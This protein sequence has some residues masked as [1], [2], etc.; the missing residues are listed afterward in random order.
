MYRK[1]LTWLALPATPP[2]H[3][4]TSSSCSTQ[5]FFYPRYALRVLRLSPL[6]SHTLISVASPQTIFLVQTQTSLC[7]VLSQAQIPT[8]EPCILKHSISMHMFPHHK[9]ANCNPELNVTTI[10]SSFVSHFLALNTF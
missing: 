3:L 4:L 8:H 1:V 10:S 6:N 2:L 5:P 7:C 9:D